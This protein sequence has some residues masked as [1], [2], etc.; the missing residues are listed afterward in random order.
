MQDARCRPT[1]PGSIRR[2]FLPRSTA[3][4]L[5]HFS[6]SPY[7]VLSRARFIKSAI[8]LFLRYIHAW[9]CQ[10]MEM[11]RIWDGVSPVSRRPSE[12][13]AQADAY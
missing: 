12:A 5:L 9:H 6:G 4:A 1:R 3:L 2:T 8:S 7:A 13:V 11:N 10:G